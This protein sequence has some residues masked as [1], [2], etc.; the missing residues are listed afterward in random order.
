MEQPTQIITL[1]Q[2]DYNALSTL[3]KQSG[4]RNLRLNTRI[5]YNYWK[6]LFGVNKTPNGCPSCMRSDL[7]NFASRWNELERMGLI[8]IAEKN[9]E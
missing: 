2:E 8:Q 9:N 6:T 3:A 5:I 7:T 4:M 1:S